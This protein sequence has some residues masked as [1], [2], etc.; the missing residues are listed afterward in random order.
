MRQLTEIRHENMNLVVVAQDKLEQQSSANTVMSSSDMNVP[1]CY[2]V[3]QHIKLI[4]D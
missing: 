1:S 2:S 4:T 3:T